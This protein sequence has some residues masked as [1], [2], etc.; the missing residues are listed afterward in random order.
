MTDPHKLLNSYHANIL[1]DM[2]S[3]LDIVPDSGKK[4]DYVDALVRE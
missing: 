2:G 3:L 4:A 1:L